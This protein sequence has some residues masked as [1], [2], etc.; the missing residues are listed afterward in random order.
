M[1]AF[2]ILTLILL[3]TAFGVIA[4]HNPLHSALHLIVNM[5]CIAG[6]FA[7]LDAHFLATVQ[8][9]VYAGAIMVLVIFV[10]MLLNLK[11]EAPK[12]RSFLFI[13]LCV[14]SA[15]LFFLLG[16]PLFN[17]SFKVFPN[18]SPQFSGSMTDV[19]RELYTKYV[20]PFEAASILIMAAI[21]GAVMLA[22]RK[23]R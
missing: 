15:A 11:V 7:H 23:I 2:G 1:I 14:I 21:A 3:I 13:S 18:S 17:E 22:K 12:P 16:A 6:L 8:V 20:F 9:V 5:L 10:L 19:G 4:S